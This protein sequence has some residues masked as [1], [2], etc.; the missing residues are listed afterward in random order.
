MA[1]F[2]LTKA[3]WQEITKSYAT[4]FTEASIEAEFVGNVTNIGWDT[5]SEPL[6]TSAK[7][8]RPTTR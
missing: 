5:N 3:N 6:E 2:D 8:E 4:S 1:Q 7:N